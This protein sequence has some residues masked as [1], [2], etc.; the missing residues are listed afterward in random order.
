MTTAE[1]GPT[2]AY[3]EAV[4]DIWYIYKALGAYIIK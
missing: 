3:K 1:C 2:Y 4:L